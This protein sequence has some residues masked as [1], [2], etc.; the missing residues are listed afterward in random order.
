MTYSRLDR[1]LE[2][3]D[4]ANGADPRRTE[5]GLPFEIDHA[6]RLTDWVARLCPTSSEFLR[7]AARGQ[8]IERWTSPRNTFPEGRAGYL[9]WREELKKFHARR[10]GDIMRTADYS[11]AEVARVTE[12]ITKAAH[13]AGDPEGQALEDGLCLVFL[14]TQYLDLVAKTPKDKMAVIV[15]KTM[16]KM[17]PVA[18][19]YA[20][21]IISGMTQ[22][23]ATNAESKG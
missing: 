13:R 18:Q 2:A 14:E 3:I 11:P 21:A 19:S 5:A 17:S 6:Q 20:S 1:V 22:T 10:V 12:L 7:I 23:S 4:A 8:H 16:G 9:R 15:Q